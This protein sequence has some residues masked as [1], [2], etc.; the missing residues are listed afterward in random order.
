[1][2]VA[3]TLLHILMIYRMIQY[4][5]DWNAFYNVEICNFNVN[6]FFIS[7]DK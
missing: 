2:I 4:Q 6:F 3:T 1:M 5:Q 7:D